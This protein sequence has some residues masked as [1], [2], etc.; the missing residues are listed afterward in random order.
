MSTDPSYQNKIALFNQSIQIIHENTSN[1]SVLQNIENSPGFPDIV[2]M[3]NHLIMSKILK[4][5]LKRCRCD[6]LRVM[7]LFEQTKSQNKDWITLV[8]G[9]KAMIAAFVNKNYVIVK[10]GH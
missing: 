2:F 8:N 10:C 9:S 5:E 1:I 4:F 7:L 6:I 3:Q